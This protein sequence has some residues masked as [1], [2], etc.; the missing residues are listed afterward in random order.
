M[1]RKKIIAV[2]GDGNFR[3][4]EEKEKIA[5]EMGK[6]L[7]DNE[8]ILV[9]GG[10]GGVMEASSR[11]AK[12]SSN[13]KEGSVIGIIPDYNDNY[14]NQY[15][16]ILFPTGMGIARNILIVSMCDAVIAIGGKSG[17]LS[18]IAIA[19]QMEKLIVAFDVE[20]WSGE[21]KKIQIDDRRN[22][23]IFSVH[24]P[25]EAIYI[26]K[27]NISKYDKKYCG[28]KKGRIG[29]KHAERLI[30]D[31]LNIKDHIIFLGKGTEGYIFKSEDKVYK[32]IDNEP[33]ILHQYWR[34]KALSEDIQK[35]KLKY[36]F[37]F[38]VN[39]YNEY[40]IISYDYFNSRE[41]KGGYTKDIINLAKELK[42][43]GWLITDF[44]P[45]N[46]RIRL[47]D[48]RPFIID[49]GHSFEPFHEDL[50]RKMC[51]RMFVSTLI[52]DR[53]DIKIFLTETNNSEDFD[54]LIEENGYDK[55][56]RQEFNIFYKKIMTV[57]KEDLL[58]PLLIHLVDS[59]SDVNT[60][61][62][63]GSGYGDI[64]FELSK[65]GYS[66]ISYDIDE[67]L[68][69]TNI[70]N[71]KDII[72]DPF[73]GTGTTN[74]AALNTGRYCIGIEKDEKYFYP[75][76]SRLTEKRN[77]NKKTFQSCLTDKAII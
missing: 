66:V 15:S 37:D 21:L 39:Y 54:G 46:L 64:S 28:V 24:T 57:K 41:Y 61:F 49:I 23:S 18:E 20:G 26:I 45:K 42:K 12:S 73:A 62:D 56:I 40:L 53:S 48:N 36:I 4:N 38:D 68:Y 63:Y 33:N 1:P 22:D 19:W 29:D 5:F 69:K 65:E 10:L 76:I 59:L 8:Y 77:N 25:E 27:N 55:S 43:I 74:I 30:K 75:A 7:I 9:N 17:T 51:R 71:Y 34:L 13:Y 32:L 44:Q 72:L 52:G 58:N 35:H 16:D 14:C 11:G 6:L 47:T 67:S 50:F 70:H 3:G 2:I 31:N 60:I